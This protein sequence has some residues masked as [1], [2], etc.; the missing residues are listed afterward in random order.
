MR[1][2]KADWMRL[3]DH[4]KLGKDLQDKAYQHH[5]GKPLVS[6]WG[7]FENREG[8]P[9]FY[10]K[11]I[12][13]VKN[14]P[15]Y[16]GFSVMIGCENNWRTGKG[17][18]YDILREAIEKADIVSPWTVGRYN[19]PDTAETFIKRLHRPD[20]AW[21]RAH[22][23]DFLPVIFPGF[24]WHNLKQDS[25]LDQIPRRQ[26]HF[27]WRQVYENR[28]I[29]A[30]MFYVAM[31]DEVDEG[32][33]IFKVHPNPPIGKS[34]FLNYNGLPSDHYL[35]LTGKA[36]EVLDGK[37]SPTRTPPDRPGVMLRKDKINPN[38]R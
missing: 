34:P 13:F 4:M 24:S 27:L 12:D 16:G 6:I 21:C 32:T 3:V 5:N 15:H 29:G 35:W 9:E 20:I 17:E 18:K 11:V 33:A 23:I 7:L 36:Q 26:G 10:N 37:L 31:F 19:S 8:M 22:Q 2:F 25:P 1:L 38:S 14:D 28:N 30:K